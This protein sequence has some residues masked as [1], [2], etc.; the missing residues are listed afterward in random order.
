[1]A[2]YGPE[3]PVPVIGDEDAPPS[4]FERIAAER[5]AA[6]ASKQ[7]DRLGKVNPL[8]LEEYEALTELS[9]MARINPI[10]FSTDVDGAFGKRSALQTLRSPDQKKRRHDW[11]AGIEIKLLAL[12]S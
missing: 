6:E 9:Q 3:V 5:R 2:E 4:R 1:M 7:L 8:A 11:H 12:T 10:L